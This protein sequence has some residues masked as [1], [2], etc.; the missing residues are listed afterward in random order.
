MTDIQTDGQTDRQTDR[1]ADRQTDRQTH[2]QT[3]GC[4]LGA[5]HMRA[6]SR[7]VCGGPNVTQANVHVVGIASYGNHLK[8]NVYC[9]SSLAVAENNAVSGTESKNVQNTDQKSGQKV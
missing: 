2:G 1:Q 6:L 5:L 8:P 9:A 4:A 3:Q 7:T